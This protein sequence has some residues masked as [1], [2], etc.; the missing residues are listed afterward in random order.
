M[1]PR[2]S[3]FADLFHIYNEYV[4]ATISTL[5]TYSRPIGLCSSCWRIWSHQQPLSVASHA[6]QFDPAEQIQW[7]AQRPSTCS[8]RNG[9]MPCHLSATHWHSAQTRLLR[10]CA[11][12]T[13]PA[14]QW[15]CK[16]RDSSDIR[17]MACNLRGSHLDGPKRLN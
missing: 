17:P 15:I 3:N 8:A 10:P 13:W 4:Q 11:C 2:R 5:R 16:S 7:T 1:Y 9:P 12:R 6:P 14:I